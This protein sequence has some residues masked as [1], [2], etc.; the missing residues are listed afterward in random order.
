MLTMSASVGG[1]T[2]PSESAVDGKRNMREVRNAAMVFK[3]SSGHTNHP[4][5]CELVMSE[6][7]GRPLTEDHFGKLG[8]G[9]DSVVIGYPWCRG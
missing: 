5:R 6:L 4:Q 7:R 8:S 3:R 1:F 2:I 9:Q